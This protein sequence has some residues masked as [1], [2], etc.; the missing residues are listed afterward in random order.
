MPFDHYGVL[1]GT[2][3]QH[4]R[5]TPDTQGAWFH[6]NLR[7]EAPDGRY[8][9]AVD[10]DSHDSATGVRW[11]VLT[12]DASALGPVA[13]L[14][15][16]YHEL[17]RTDG[18]GALDY[19]RHPALRDHPL[20]PPLPLPRRLLDLLDRLPKPSRHWESGSNLDAARALEPIL[21]VG[22]PILVFGEPFTAGLGMHNIHQNQG[23]PYGSDWW[24]ENGIWQDGATLTRRPDG[25]YDV[26][27]NKFSTQKD[28]T[29]SDGHPA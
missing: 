14:T 20:R 7:V 17:A 28:H 10:V 18:S 11:K 15:P 27:L 12:V 21:V 13:A 8:K 22:R 29:D 4:F 24:E 16:G 26:F 9:C 23:D 25:R 3:R 5:D 19:I 2:L 1:A 6:V